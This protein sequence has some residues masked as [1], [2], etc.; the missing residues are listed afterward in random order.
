MELFIFNRLFINGS[1]YSLPEPLVDRCE[2]IK[3]FKLTAKDLV[4][5]LI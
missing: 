2:Q 5:A 1:V 4:G 3:K